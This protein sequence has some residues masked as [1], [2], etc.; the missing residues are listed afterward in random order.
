[1]QDKDDAITTVLNAA[2]F[3]IAWAMAYVAMVSWMGFEL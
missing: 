2:C 3:A 1:M